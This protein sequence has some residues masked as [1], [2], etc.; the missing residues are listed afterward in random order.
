MA[1]SNNFSV[2]MADSGGGETTTLKIEDAYIYDMAMQLAIRAGDLQTRIDA[3]IS[4]IE[5]I[6]SNAILEGD[7][8]DAL[9]TFI[10]YAK[11]LNNIVLESGTNIKTLLENYMTEVDAAD[12]YLYTEK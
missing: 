9:D 11:G 6:R 8:A 3:Y 1:I 5:G 7:T 10:T 12:E 2:A 4:C